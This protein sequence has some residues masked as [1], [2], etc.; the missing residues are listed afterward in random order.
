MKRKFKKL[1]NI[2]RPYLVISK[3]YLVDFLSRQVR[4]SPNGLISVIGRFVFAD[5]KRDFGFSEEIRRHLEAGEV[6][7]AD[8]RCIEALN[9][10]PNSIKLHSM[11]AEVSMY[12]RDFD[13]AERRWTIVIDKFKNDFEGYE[14][15]A[16]LH[17]C[18]GE[19]DTA[20]SICKKGMDR[21]PHE[22]WSYREF[23][24]VSMSRKDY[25]EALERWKVLR[26]KFPNERA[27]YV[28]AAQ[29]FSELGDYK[30]AKELYNQTLK[31]EVNV[32]GLKVGSKEG[33]KLAYPDSEMTE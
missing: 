28:R 17:Y 16:R 32:T 10:L 13:E 19:Y 2:S 12:K 27:G 9:V 6:D 29:A 23:A 14:G 21:F 1:I 7:L 30:K 31:A 18:R 11:Y 25:A 3:T 5:T 20:E 8:K 22:P 24:E 26:E 33:V 15:K 4:N